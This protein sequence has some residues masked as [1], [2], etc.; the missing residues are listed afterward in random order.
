[1]QNIEGRI[2]G[3]PA[4][5]CLSGSSFQALCMIEAI[6]AFEITDYRVLLCLSENELPR[7]G[8]ITALL[9][10][11]HIAYEIESV[12]FRIT[13]VERMI[14]MLPQ[15][16]KY[17]VAF[18]GDCNNELLIF[19]AFRYVSDDGTLVYLDDGIATIQFFNGMFQLSNK[20]RPYYNLMSKIRRIDFD[21]YFYT[22]YEDLTD[23]RHIPIICH[24]NY[25]TG[26]HKSKTN[27]RGIYF[28]GTQVKD[29]CD[30]EGVPVDRF[31]AVLQGLLRELRSQY[32]DDPVIYVPHGRETMS[33]ELTAMCLEVGVEYR[34]SE[35]SVEMMLLEEK[36]YP[37]AVFGFTSSALYNIKKI[38]PETEVFNITFT[39][40]SPKTNG[41]EI[42]SQ[43]YA[44]FGITRKIIDL[45][46]KDERDCS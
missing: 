31:M 11:F 4:V 23:N 29:Y 25:L 17:K 8:Q 18:I 7:Q 30:F 44:K 1:M 41:K 43:Y 46:S 39:G 21:R 2:K 5:F 38:F 19:K 26:L 14:A 33:E 32:P 28:I 40:N 12:C 9:D 27:V 24:F 15:R 45:N 22:V 10:K 16:N 3:Q 37:R 20:L 36:N 35:I 13:K 6:Q 34:P 42:T